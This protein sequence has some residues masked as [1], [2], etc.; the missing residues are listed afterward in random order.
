[1]PRR[2]SSLRRGFF[3]GL[4]RRLR[5]LGT[6]LVLGSALLCALPLA[7]QDS[8]RLPQIS[9]QTS[10]RV[11]SGGFVSAVGTR[12]ALLGKEDGRFEAWVYPLKIVRD[13]HVRFH[14]DGRVVEGED[15][16]RNVITRPESATI[17][18]SEGAFQVR[19][20]LFVPIHEPGASIIFE[21]HTE[22]P[23][24]IEVAFQCD[25]ELEWPAVLGAASLDWNPDRRAFL[26][27]A[28]QGQ[29][30]NKDQNKDQNRDQNE[31]QNKDR[32]YAAW[33]GSPTASDAQSGAKSGERTGDSSS[34]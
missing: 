22:R 2:S 17:V 27:R 7:S 31:D 12:A 33:I 3:A 11:R 16:A 10:P 32:N 14:I 21:V 20:T 23:L 28:N 18:Y 29:Q 25:F 8:T 1:M 9:N 30:Q 4:L 6:G 26:L 15:V 19:E 34:G 13:L 24:A 5:K